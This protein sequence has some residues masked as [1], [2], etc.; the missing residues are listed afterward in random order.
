M[1]YE[2]VAQDS[3]QLH[4]LLATGWTVNPTCTSMT[5]NFLFADF[6]E[7]FSFMTAVALEAERLNHHPE[8]SNVY[9]RL[10]ITWSTHDINGL[11]TH[12]LRMAEYCNKLREK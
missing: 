4:A 9:N 5:H 11:S 8:W 6:K 1:S 12:D 10:S 2:P 3:P 7:A